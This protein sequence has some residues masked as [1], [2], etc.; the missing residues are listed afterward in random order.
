MIKRCKCTLG[1]FGG[2]NDAAIKFQN[3]KY[4]EGMRVMNPLKNKGYRCSVCGQEHSSG[5]T[6]RKPQKAK[7]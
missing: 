5:D 7:K 3:A 1:D 4:G 6:E 2:K